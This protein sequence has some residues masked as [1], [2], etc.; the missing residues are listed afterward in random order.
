MEEEEEEKN[1]DN[2]IS[3]KTTSQLL[4]H[5]KYTQPLFKDLIYIPEKV[6]IN[7]K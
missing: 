4:R 3:T 6:G 2:D 1:F 5:L 7:K